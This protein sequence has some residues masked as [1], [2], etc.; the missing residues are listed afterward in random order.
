MRALI[1]DDE[2]VARRVLREQLEELEGVAIVGE[3]ENG[4]DAEPGVRAGIWGV[5]A[6]GDGDARGHP[7]CGEPGR[8]VDVPGPAGRQLG[9]AAA[10]GVLMSDSASGRS[11]SQLVSADQWARC[12]HQGT[13]LLPDGTVQL[14]WYDETDPAPRS[15]AAPVAGRRHIRPG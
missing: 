9:A 8:E 7:E 13:A 12:A 5:G 2:P 3:A 4:A 15:P 11:Y 6:A 1:I 14:T 10:G